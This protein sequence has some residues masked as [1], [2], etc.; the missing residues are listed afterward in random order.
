MLSL[1]IY[2]PTYNRLQSLMRCLDCIKRD[3]DG[4]EEQVCVYVSNNASTDG[5]KEY[6]D[7]LS[8]VKKRHNPL[9]LGA[10]K[11]FVHAYDLPFETKFVWLLGDDDYVIP[12]AIWYLERNST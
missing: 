8:W 12:G 11:N 3:I 5:T 9:N 1:T 6:L 10:A 7:S 4:Y 2:I